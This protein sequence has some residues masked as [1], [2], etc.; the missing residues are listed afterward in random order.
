[1]SD[2]FIDGQK[3]P[4]KV[5]K[6]VY[7]GSFHENVK[8]R[9]S[10]TTITWKSSRLDELLWIQEQCFERSINAIAQYHGMVIRTAPPE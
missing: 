7:H 5:E 8:L 9:G 3:V 2:L 4:G 1:M 10:V 6:I